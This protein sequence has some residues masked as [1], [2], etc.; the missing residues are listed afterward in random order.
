LQELKNDAHIDRPIALQELVFNGYPDAHQ[1]LDIVRGL[2]TPGL[3][4]FVCFGLSSGDGAH[5]DEAMKAVR[6]AFPNLTTLD[7]PKPKSEHNH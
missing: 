1:L 7:F 5:H 3:R 2:A 6:K 4:T